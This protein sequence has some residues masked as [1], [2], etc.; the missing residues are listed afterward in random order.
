MFYK[1]KNQDGFTLVELMVCI[2]IIGI[3]SA[4]AIPNYI[5]Y[6]ERGLIAKAQSELKNLEKAVT[7]LGI[8]TGRWPNKDPIDNVDTLEVEDLNLDIAGI[9]ATDGSYPDWMGPYMGKV[10]QDP[11]GNNYFFDPDYEIDGLDYVV[12]GSY[13]PNGEG[14]NDYDADDVIVVLDGPY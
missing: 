13:G 12:I 9:A 8:D 5:R 3:L 14:L 7:M 2:A 6:R 4:I 1:V 11:W 10:P